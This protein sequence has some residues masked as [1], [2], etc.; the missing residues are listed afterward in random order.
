MFSWG[1]LAL[2]LGA[3]AALFGGLHFLSSN[4]YRV[5]NFSVKFCNTDFRS[6]EWNLCLIFTVL[7]F[8]FGVEIRG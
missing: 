7:G 1:E 6:W 4:S 2:I 5:V 3:S 8:S